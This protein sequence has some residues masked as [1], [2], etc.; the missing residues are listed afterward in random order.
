MTKKIPIHLNNKDLGELK[1]LAY[2][3]NLSNTYGE[4]PKTIKFSITF[5]LH[6]LKKIEKSIPD[7]NSDETMILLSSIKRLRDRRTK[8][9]KAEELKKEA[10]KV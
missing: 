1:E 5:A 4:V 7:L 6:T 3:L 9:E 10:E 8:L 2:L